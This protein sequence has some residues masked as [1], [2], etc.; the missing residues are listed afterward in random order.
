MC[1]IS[2]RHQRWS[3]SS[4]DAEIPQS[5]REGLGQWCLQRSSSYQSTETS[6]PVPESQE[7]LYR[8]YNS[9]CAEQVH[10]LFLSNDSST[11]K[12]N[13][14]LV[15]TTCLKFCL[16]LAWHDIP[17]G[18]RDPIFHP[19]MRLFVCPSTLVSSISSTLIFKFIPEALQGRLIPSGGDIAF[20]KILVFFFF[21][22]FVT[23]CPLF[24]KPSSSKKEPTIKG[25][26]LLPV[27]ANSFLY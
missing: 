3:E 17:V 16:L 25:K 13:F 22:F 10:V 19:S 1:N 23:S 9:E 2:T 12:P 18:D 6:K 7:R 8:C 4:W 21:L 24:C 14:G 27:G 5:A 26:N 20:G 11:L 15:K